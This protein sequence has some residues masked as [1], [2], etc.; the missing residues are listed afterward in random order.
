MPPRGDRQR[1]DLP[2]G[3]VAWEEALDIDPGH[4]RIRRNLARLAADSGRPEEARNY[5]AGLASDGC[6]DE[7]FAAEIESRIAAANPSAASQSPTTRDD[8][9]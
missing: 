6:P 8:G 9:R 1:G 5:V 7:D 2:A 3:R 4:P